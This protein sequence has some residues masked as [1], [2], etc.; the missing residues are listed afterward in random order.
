LRSLRE[1]NTNRGCFTMFLPWPYSRAWSLGAIGAVLACTAG[2]WNAA[3]EGQ[4]P[5]KPTGDQTVRSEP[6]SP[7][8]KDRKLKPF[9]RKKLGASNQILE[10]LCTDDLDLVV[11]GAREL[12]QMSE[13]E[14]WRVSN[15]AVYRQFSTEF[16]QIT[17]DL[18]QAAQEG[19]TDR[20]LLKWL[21]ATMSCVDCHQFVR[22]MRIADS[23]PRSEA[24]QP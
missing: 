22:G 19:K 16:H 6:P 23:R 14:Q 10:G 1:I 9:M 21:D 7:N 8:S 12:H 17:K 15:D 20:A 4:Q 11:K 3:S 2:L 5:S 13:A 18:V 24:K